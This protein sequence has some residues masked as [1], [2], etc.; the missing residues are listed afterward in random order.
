MS[1]QRIIRGIA[2]GLE[3][4]LRSTIDDIVAAFDARLLGH[5]RCACIEN[6]S[7]VGRRL[8]VNFTPR[9]SHICA[10]VDEQ[11]LRLVGA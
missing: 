5:D 8:D 1:G 6:R 3:V 2:I 11:G 9:A 4:G 7:R 10:T